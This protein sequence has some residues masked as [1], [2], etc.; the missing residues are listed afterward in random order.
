MTRR[1]KP[2]ARTLASLAT[3]RRR[4]ALKARIWFGPAGAQAL[5]QP[6]PLAPGLRACAS[7]TRRRK[8][9]ARTL[10][11]LATSRRRPA[12]KERMWFGPAGLRRSLNQCPGAGPSRVLTDRRVDGSR[13]R[14][15]SAPCDATHFVK[16][17]DLAD[18]LVR[19][20]TDDARKAQRVARFVALAGLDL[21]E[22]HLDHAIRLDQPEAAVVADGVREE[23]LGHLGDLLVRETRVGLSDVEQALAV[24]D[25]EGVVGEDP[26]AFPVAPLDAR[27][28][29]VE[30]AKRALH[31]EPLHAAA[32]GAVR[33]PRVLDHE[34]FVAPLACRRELALE[35]RRE[36]IAGLGDRPLVREQDRSLERD[37]SKDRRALGE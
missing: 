6:V 3:S 12:I 36:W 24:A 29:D 37:L 5:A 9:A 19:P 20:Q 2:A 16:S 11:S 13:R 31:L 23:V 10:A 14:V 30:R 7:E 18:G 27:D 4:P 32:A 17:V 15:F 33:R 25:R 35:R 26:P 21:V 1:R 34:P 8:P 22:R 28:H